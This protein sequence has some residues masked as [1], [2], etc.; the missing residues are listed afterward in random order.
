MNKLIFL[1]PIII[2]LFCPVVAA[3]EKPDPSKRFIQG[4]KYMRMAKWAGAE[5]AFLDVLDSW[6]GHPDVHALL[7][8]TRY[9][10]GKY[11]AA[12]DDL[13]YARRK[14]T[15]YKPRVLYYLSLIHI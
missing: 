12:K 5:Q 4:A 6:P 14:G 8:I 7:G 2:V 9:H 10:L 1:A 13:E 3:S 15:K 11:S